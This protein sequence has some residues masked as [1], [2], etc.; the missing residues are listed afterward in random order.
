MA[1]SQEQPHQPLFEKVEWLTV[2]DT[3]QNYS[4]ATSLL[5]TGAVSNN[6]S[7][8]IDYNKSYLRIPLIITLSNKTGEK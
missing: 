3:Q 6:S 8:W 4:Q 2:Q 5:E 1:K 7:F